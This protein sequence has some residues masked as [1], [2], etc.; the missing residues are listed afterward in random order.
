MA[1]EIRRMV[2]SHSLPDRFVFVDWCP[3]GPWVAEK[4]FLPDMFTFKFRTQFR[5]FIPLHKKKIIYLRN[6]KNHQVIQ[7]R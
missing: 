3:S 5:S 4:H 7:Y 2:Y 1:K 6:E